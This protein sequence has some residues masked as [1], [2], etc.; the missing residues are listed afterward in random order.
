MLGAQPAGSRVQLSCQLKGLTARTAFVQVDFFGKEDGR[1]IH[2][3]SHWQP[4]CLPVSPK[5]STAS[6]QDF[7]PDRFSRLKDLQAAVLLSPFQT[8]L[9]YLKPR[10]AQRSSVLIRNASLRLL[11]ALDIPGAGAPWLII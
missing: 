1:T 3:I 5:W 10:K 7:L 9:L 6:F 8:D 11:P 2:W 4:T